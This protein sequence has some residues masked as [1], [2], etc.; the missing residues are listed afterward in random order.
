MR[1]FERVKGA[2]GADFQR[3]DAVL[4][5]VHRAGGR[6]EVEDV[7][8][9]AVIEGLVHVL[10]AEFEASVVAEMFEIVRAAG[11]EII[12]RDHVMAVAEQR[13]TEMR[14]EES[15]AAGHEC[16]HRRYSLTLPAVRLS[17]PRPAAPATVPRPTL[18]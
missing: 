12:H 13:F 2:V 16:A 3:G 17:A 1:Q 5:V 7:I 6:S 15:G 14:A 11:E 10:L 9:L 18:T 4:H 8:H